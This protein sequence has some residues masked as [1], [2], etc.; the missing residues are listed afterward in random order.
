MSQRPNVL[1][2]MADQ[3]RR[4]AMGCYGNPIV[5]TP[6]LDALSRRGV[7]F[8]HMYAAYPV[9]APNR[10]SIITGQHPHSNG[11]TGLSHRHKRLMLSPFKTT[12]PEVLD[13]CGYHT[14]IEGKW[15]V[16][17]YLP[18]G[19]YGYSERLSGI[20]PKDF[21]IRSPDQALA[22]IE[23]NR[24]SAF[25]LELAPRALEALASA[26]AATRLTDADLAA[27]LDQKSNQVDAAK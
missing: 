9:C 11:V 10:A 8:E 7:R 13:E 26:P 6:N 25:Y 14:A 3:M 24:E 22:F 15:H 2:I 5:Q 16:A 17:P 1:F 27:S 4:D 19:W 18:T 23:E 21:W 12:L 20:L